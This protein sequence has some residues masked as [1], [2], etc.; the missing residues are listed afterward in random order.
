MPDLADIRRGLNDPVGALSY[1]SNRLREYTILSGLD[2]YRWSQGITHQTPLMHKFVDQD[3]F[4]LIVLDACRYDAFRD[5]ITTYLEGRLHLVWAAGRWTADYSR[6]T[7]TRDDDLTYLAS[8]PVVS[9]FYFELRNMSYRPS[10][11]IHRLIPLWKTDWD[12][13]IG[14]VPPAAVTDAAL[15][16]ADSPEATRLVAHYAQPHAPYVGATEILPWEE[17]PGSMRHLL[18]EDID[19][20]NQRIYKRIQQ[21]DISEVTLQRAY[22]DNL[23]AVLDEVVRLVHRVDCPVVITAD[24]GEHL[25][26]RGR[27]LH[28]EESCLIRQIPWFVVDPQETSQKTI[29]RDYEQRT[30]D[31]QTAVSEEIKEKLADLGYT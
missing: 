28:E 24:H 18:S 10:D 23:E 26:E 11:H 6:R 13:T 7:W 3:E 16:H 21:G 2:I 19:R 30:V 5:Q 12:R 17:E 1:V 20:P 15:A 8:V 14:T 9:D 25:G 31:E 27:Y 29:T 4:V 22:R